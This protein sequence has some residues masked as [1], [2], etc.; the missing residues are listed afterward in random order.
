MGRHK[1]TEASVTNESGETKP[2]NAEVQAAEAVAE[3][4]KDEAREAKESGTEGPA[5]R[6]RGRPKKVKTRLKLPPQMIQM[7]ADA[8]L[9]LDARVSGMFG[10]VPIHN[11]ELVKLQRAMMFEWLGNIEI[12]IHPMWLYLIAT[13][14]TIATAQRLTMEQAQAMAQ[15]R[16]QGPQAPPPVNG[17]P[18][19]AS[20]PPAATDTGSA[21]AASG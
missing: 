1:K 12:D 18:H 16:A 10:R 4:E 19:A 15:A 14:A 3:L 9:L 11:P 13:L 6:G 8:P 17:A 21:S 20:T 5:K 7:A 2:V